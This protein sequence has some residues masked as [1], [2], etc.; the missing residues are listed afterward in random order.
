MSRNDGR[1]IILNKDEVYRKYFEERN[2][3]SISHYT[4][5][6]IKYPT[7]SEI[8]SKLTVVG[9]IWKVGDR[10]YKLAEKHYGDPTLWWLIAW[11]NQRPLESD[12]KTGE[13]INIALPAEEAMLL[14]KIGGK[15]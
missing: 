4:T 7:A 8:A 5:P 15:K 1:T 3:T 13:V 9:H 12:N 14:Y 10:Y 6:H 2:L 11:F